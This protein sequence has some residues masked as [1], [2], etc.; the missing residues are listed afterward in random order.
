MHLSMMPY[1]AK[2]RQAFLD[3]VDAITVAPKGK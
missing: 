1:T 2:D 3:F